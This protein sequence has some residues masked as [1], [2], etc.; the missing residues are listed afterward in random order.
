M[1][2]RG[3]MKRWMETREVFERLTIADVEEP[4][5]EGLRFALAT[6]VSVSGSAYRRAGAKLLVAGD[7]STWGNVSGGCLEE[8]VREIAL[9]VIE[10]GRSEVRTYCTGAGEVEAWDLGV[11]CEGVVEVH[12]APA[13]AGEAVARVR[14]LLEG[15]RSFVVVTSLDPSSE[16]APVPSMSVTAA[17]WNSGSL[18]SPELDALATRTA[19]DLLEG[20]APRRLHLLGR[21]LFF[22]LLVPPPLLL[23]VG[24]GEDS[25][26]LA[27]LAVKVGFRVDVADRR[28]G[29]LAP[30]FFPKG[31]RVRQLASAELS[32]VALDRE[33]R[34]VVMTHNYGEDLAAL[35]ALIDTEAGY[36]GVL[37]PR[38]RT[39]RLLTT[40]L[41]ERPESVNRVHG[42]V[43][44]DIGGEGAEAVALSIL[45]EILTLP[46]EVEQ[47][48]ED[49]AVTSHV[50]AG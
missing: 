39:E 48:R 40:L 21:H 4:R 44:L 38:A 7:G 11:G 23:V 6:V 49:R 45:A 42:P 47:A 5:S 28:P 20:G 50:V 19:I 26:P 37:G 14:E 18:G 9:R 3:R 33:S 36:I 41:T 12:I 1:T 32:G 8:D 46:V 30:E 27:E 13:P 10:S 35:R 22:D 24:A 25:H 15:D 34:V 17:G 31:V 29:K 2:D 16:T 43:G